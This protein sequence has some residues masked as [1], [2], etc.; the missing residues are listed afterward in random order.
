MIRLENRK[1]DYGILCVITVDFAERHRVVVLFL[2]PANLSLVQ[3]QEL[4][5]TYR[6]K[7]PTLS[8]RAYAGIVYPHN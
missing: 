1:V 6:P 8:R 3:D 5:L 4:K 2:Y 7:T